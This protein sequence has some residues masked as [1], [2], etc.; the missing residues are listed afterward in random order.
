[1]DRGLTT[2]GVIN[3]ESSIERC[4]CACTYIDWLTANSNNSKK[5]RHVCNACSGRGRHHW[6]TGTPLTVYRY[7]SLDRS[8]CDGRQDRIEKRVA[9]PVIA[10]HFRAGMCVRG[11]GWQ[12][13]NAS[14]PYV[15]ERLLELLQRYR[16]LVHVLVRPI[17]RAIL[18]ARWWQSR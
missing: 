18:Y 15:E 17:G 2:I 7:M 4:T 9:F 8:A 10:C 3:V 5:F 12:L 14:R 13:L 11:A 6:L 1:M 16:R